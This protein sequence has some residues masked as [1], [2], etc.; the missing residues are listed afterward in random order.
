MKTAP[1]ST[2]S[3]YYH[4]YQRT[5]IIGSH[6]PTKTTSICGS[7]RRVSG[8]LLE[9]TTIRYRPRSMSPSRLEGVMCGLKNP[10]RS[11]RTRIGL[12]SAGI[13]RTLSGTSAGTPF[14]LSAVCRP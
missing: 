5:F 13:R 4:G 12:K 10:T 1:S 11:P 7:M 3:Y 6:T 14:L 2:G 9:M 8:C